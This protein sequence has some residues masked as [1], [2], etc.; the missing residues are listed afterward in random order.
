MDRAKQLSVMHYLRAAVGPAAT[1]VGDG[2]LLARFAMHRDQAAFELLLWRH[3]G[4]V[5]RTCESVLRDH[6]AA[7]DACQAAFLALARKAGSISRGDAVAGWLHRVARRIA[8][9]L[10]AQRA[11][12]Q[13]ASGDAL[14]AIAG[15][16]TTFDVAEAPLL[17]EEVARLPERYR[18]PVVLCFFEGLT[19]T[20]A[21]TR[22]GWP[23]GTVA[24][25]LARAKNLLH[26]RL[27]RSGVTCP[28]VGFAAVALADSAAAVSSAFVSVTGHAAVAVAARSAVVP[29]ISP[30]VL[31]LSNGALRTMAYTKLQWAACAA[32]LTGGMFTGGMWAVGQAPSAPAPAEAPKPKELSEKPAPAKQEFPRAT[33]TQRAKSANNL[34]QLMIAIHNYHDTNGVFPH[35]VTDNAGKPL[36]SW[37]V[38]ILPYM[39]QAYLYRSFKLDEPWDSDNNKPLMAQMPACLKVGIEPAKSTD[40][41]YQFFSGEG[42]A[43]EFGKK[44]RFADITDGSSN[45]LGIVEAGP[46]VPWSKPADI[47]YDPKNPPKLAGPFSNLINVSMMDGSTK[48]YRPTIDETLLHQLIT[49]AGGE[50]QDQDK[51]KTAFAPRLPLTPEEKREAADALK[52]SKSLSEELTKIL[53]QRSAL[54]EDLY[55][56]RIAAELGGNETPEGNLDLAFEYVRVLEAL[57]K[58]AKRMNADIQLEID[59][60]KHPPKPV[61]KDAPKE[62]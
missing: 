36:L 16:A 15:S 28:T 29:S 47:A 23:V 17:H 25:R 62:K 57:T 5:H 22:L 31:L 1:G 52:K 20:D 18:A 45:T 9:R 7:E 32:V 11:K 55:R 41:Y 2:E 37:R 13:A 35:D 49:R 14:A 61:I 33:L 19:Q 60:R 21:A 46:P 8:V 12:Q 59:A 27:T 54:L 3:A 48:A 24:G 34:K 56:L 51:L 42:A 58:E 4:M 53:T 44:L 38:Q 30:Q 10:A 39:E 40:T 50:V 43:L 6:H 26:R